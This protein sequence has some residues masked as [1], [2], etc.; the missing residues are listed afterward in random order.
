MFGVALPF[1]PFLLLQDIVFLKNKTEERTA[2]H[3]CLISKPSFCFPGTKVAG[4]VRIL[5][6]N[7]FFLFISVLEKAKSQS[8]QSD[9]L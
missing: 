3:A 7:F 8:T 5:K 1:S 6:K 2:G 9:S 4:L